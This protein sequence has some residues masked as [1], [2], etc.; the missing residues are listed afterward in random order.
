MFLEPLNVSGPCLRERSWHNS[1][2]TTL[3]I[4]K[5]TEKAIRLEFEAQDDSIKPNLAKIRKFQKHTDSLEQCVEWA[6][7]SIRNDREQRRREL[8]HGTGAF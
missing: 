8:D 3:L 4:V 5:W 2:S 1:T 6:I 7:N